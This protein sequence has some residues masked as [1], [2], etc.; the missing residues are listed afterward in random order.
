MIITQTLQ[1][2]LPHVPVYTSPKNFNGE[3]G[4]SLSIFEIETYTPSVLGMISVLWI[5]SKKLLT[6][7]PTAQKVLLLEY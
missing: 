2:L 4:M 7:K 6:T 5:A 1:Q 3:L